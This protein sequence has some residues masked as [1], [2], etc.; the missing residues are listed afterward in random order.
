MAGQHAP[1]A[2]H[3][4]FQHSHDQEVTRRPRRHP[5]KSVTALNPIIDEY[6]QVLDHPAIKRYQSGQ[7]VSDYSHLPFA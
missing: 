1:A 4:I 7:I 2:S 3:E 6:T 5:N